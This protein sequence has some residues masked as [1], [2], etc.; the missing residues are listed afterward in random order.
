MNTRQAQG[1]A[2]GFGLVVFVG[3]GELRNH[4]CG[5]GPNGHETGERDDSWK[6]NADH[7]WSPFRRVGRS[8]ARCAPQR[9]AA[10]DTDMG[11]LTADQKGLPSHMYSRSSQD[12]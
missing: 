5:N 10:T 2:G 11:T 1:P 6:N 9:C 3:L 7:I 8:D 12:I 4:S